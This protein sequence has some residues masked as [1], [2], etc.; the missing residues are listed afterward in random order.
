MTFRTKKIIKM[1]RKDALRVQVDTL[2][3]ENQ[4]LEV[5]NLKLRRDNLNQAHLVDEL[6]ELRAAK[7]EL[8]HRLAVMEESY[9]KRLEEANA[10]CGELEVTCEQLSEH[11]GRAEQQQVEDS[12]R[13]EDL[14]ADLMAE[15]D[16]SREMELFHEELKLE[17]ERLMQEAEQQELRHLRTIQG[18]RARWEKREDLLY[19]QL[20]ILQ[21][22]SAPRQAGAQTSVRE[23]IPRWLLMFCSGDFPRDE[24]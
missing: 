9:K 8:P 7:E 16:R 4:G 6:E 24:G 2:R 1:S 19:E 20:R 10:L 17:V 21:R 11:K 13:I 3:L 12:Q 5:E 23:T 15:T 14:T 22:M 18:E